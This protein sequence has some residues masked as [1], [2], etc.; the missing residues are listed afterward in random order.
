[1][2]IGKAAKNLTQADNAFDYVLGYAAGNDLTSR[3]W[4]DPV[5]AGGQHGYAKAFDKFAPIGPV[6]VSTQEIPD[7]SQL[8]LKTLV[9]GEQRQHTKTDDL[10][11]DVPA[12]LRHLSCGRTLR[13]GTVIMTGTPSG[14]AAFRKPQPWLQNGDVVEVEISR[15]G[16]IRNKMVSEAED[17]VTT[18][19]G[20]E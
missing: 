18:D 9:N 4:Q 2:V 12:I 6:L 14:A 8:T 20:D 16:R 15:I 17:S 19:D 5:R 11:F 7:P 10:I 1:V 13:P 3:Y